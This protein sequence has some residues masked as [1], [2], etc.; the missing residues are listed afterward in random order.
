MGHANRDFTQFDKMSTDKLKEALRYYIALPDDNEVNTDAILHISEVIA[1]REKAEHPEMYPNAEEEWERFV[2]LYMPFA[3]EDDDVGYGI[4]HDNVVPITNADPSAK[5]PKVFSG[6]KWRSMGALTRVASIVIVFVVLFF[7][8]TGVA[9]A[10]G[11]NVF[12]VVATWTDDIFSF[13]SKGGS[14]TTT[15]PDD[16]IGSATYGSLQAALDACGVDVKI[17]PKWIPE[18]YCFSGV[19]ADKLGDEWYIVAY[20]DKDNG[21]SITMV[22]SSLTTAS[23]SAVEKDTQGMSKYKRGGITH[24]IMNNLGDTQAVWLNE[25]YECVLAGNNLSKSELKQ[26]I[27]SIYW[28]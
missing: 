15:V 14:L 4:E 21:D 11:Y 10:A 1:K 23:F 9:S 18:G 7:A 13:K 17:A 16:A 25:N 26:I 27:N 8:G 28:R 5:S 6:S 22:I 2:T 20:Y 3:D 24:Y 19:S 12:D